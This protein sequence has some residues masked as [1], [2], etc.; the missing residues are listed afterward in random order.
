MKGWRKHLGISNMLGLCL[1][2]SLVLWAWG[3]PA[4]LAFLPLMV[5]GAMVGGTFLLLW[6]YG[7]GE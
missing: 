4:F 6:W 7:R 5:A 3:I 2:L 1:L